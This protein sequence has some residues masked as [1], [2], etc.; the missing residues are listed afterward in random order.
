[1]TDLPRLAALAAMLMLSSAHGLAQ[2]AYPSRPIRILVG[3]TAGGTTDIIARVVGQKMNES[4]G[5]AVTIDNRPAAGGI[6]AGAMVAQAP[7][8]GYTLLV[9]SIGPLAISP[10]L[11]TDMP[12][13][14]LRAF[15][16]ITMLAAV[17][18]VLVVHPSLPVRDF[19]EYLAYAKANP[20]KINFGSTGVGT[21]AH[22]SGELMKQVAG[23]DMV[24]VPY[25]GAVA[26]N[27]LLVGRIETMFA[28]MP[29]VI[30]H[31]R[32]NALRPI[33]VTSAKRAATLP[34]TPTVA[35]SG[36]PGFESSSWFAMLGPAGMAPEIQRKLHG[37]VVRILNLPDVR[38]SLSDQGADPVGNTPEELGAYIRSETE[39]WA[40]I[41]KA[42]GIKAE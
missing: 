17:S 34:D 5:Q 40:K 3:F 7:P 8:D 35:E 20:G 22:L 1:M 12:Y 39:K 37:E 27:D 32:A 14:N 10:S 36:F 2:D 19:K 9:G 29:S 30:G 11:K 18:N 24:H 4:W 26:V 41:I 28:T 23:L 21:A 6:V 16:P 42:A 13:D 33:A 38:T 15:A 31:V 25:R